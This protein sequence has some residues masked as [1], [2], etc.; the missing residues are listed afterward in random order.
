MTPLQNTHLPCL[1]LHYAMLMVS[2]PIFNVLPALYSQP[3]RVL[4]HVA[5]QVCQNRLSPF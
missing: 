5:S 4:D 3:L 1:A 2:L